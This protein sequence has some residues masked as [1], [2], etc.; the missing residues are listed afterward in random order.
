MVSK[1]T[2]MEDQFMHGAWRRPSP[3]LARRIHERLERQDLQWSAAHRRPMLRAASYVAATVVAAGAFTLPPVRAGA[4]AVL[5]L[6][7]VINF[8]PVQVQAEHLKELATRTDLDLPHLLGEQVEVL[9]D[10]GTP[11]EVI[12][13]QAAGTAAGI[14]M[15]MPLWLPVGMS[16]TQFMVAGETQMRVTMDTRKLTTLLDALG[17]RDLRVP[18]GIDGQSAT[19]DI[20]RIAS[21]TFRDAKRQVT[22]MQARQPVAVLPD[23]VDIPTLAEIGL[24]ILGLEPNQAYAFA[25]NV[26]WRTTLLVPV[27]ANVGNFR[28]LQV[29]GNQGLLIEHPVKDAQGKDAGTITQIMWSE[30]SSV[31]VIMGNVHAEELFEMAQSLQ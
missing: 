7:R 23:G 14:R 27:P 19:L 13:A 21:A 5:D 4:A 15:R 16:A 1:E 25:R 11:R 9:M 8:A 12:D 10:P 6:F 20:P 17:I 2:D 28:Q 22:L 31:Y 29:Q 18:A 26:D 24:R 30:G 3:Q